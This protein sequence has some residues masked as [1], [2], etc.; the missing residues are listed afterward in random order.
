MRTHTN[1]AWKVIIG[2]LAFIV[3]QFIYSLLASSL[4]CEPL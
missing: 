3:V 1:N 2:I 4:H